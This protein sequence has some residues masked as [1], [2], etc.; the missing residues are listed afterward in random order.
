MIAVDF[1]PLRNQNREAAKRFL[2]V[3]H[4]NPNNRPPHV[5]GR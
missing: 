4:A 3:A 1:Y 5:Y 2:Q